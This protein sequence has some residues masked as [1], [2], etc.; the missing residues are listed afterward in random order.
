MT[1]AAT[2]APAPAQTPA[3]APVTPP[4][5][6]ADLVLTPGQE[7]R[8]Q[9]QAMKADPATA[10]RW[11]DGDPATLAKIKELQAAEFAHNYTTG[12]LMIGGPSPEQ[13]AQET[14]HYLE[15]TTG[16]PA[17]VIDQVR[18]RTPISIDEYRMS[19]ARKDDLFADPDWVQRFMAGGRKEAHELKLTQIN[20]TSPIRKD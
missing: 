10:K 17:A 11:I 7:A 13:A 5:A 15:Q 16:F 12:Q 4:A 19:V 8:A 1:D 14:A 6:A 9:I 18:N 20:R 3:A 2:P